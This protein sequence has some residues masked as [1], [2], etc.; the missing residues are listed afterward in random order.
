MVYYIAK[1]IWVV[2]TLRYVLYPLVWLVIAAGILAASLAVPILK[3]QDLNI[4]SVAPV[5]LR[6]VF[7]PN[8]ENLSSPTLEGAR[9]FSLTILLALRNLRSAGT[10]LADIIFTLSKSCQILELLCNLTTDI[11]Y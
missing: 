11:D 6:S 4:G 2:K 8:Y 1:R 10:V 3:T 9:I 7:V 5:N